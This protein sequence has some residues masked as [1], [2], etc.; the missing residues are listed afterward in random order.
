MCHLI[1]LTLIVL[2]INSAIYHY[3]RT[4]STAYCQK[5]LFVLEECLLQIHEDMRED[6]NSAASALI[7]SIARTQHCCLKL[8]T[9][10]FIYRAFTRPKNEW[11]PST[12]T[13]SLD[14]AVP[15][16]FVNFLIQFKGPVISI[17]HTIFLLVL[18]VSPFN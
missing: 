9:R 18:E 3:Y 10:W 15:A 14:T 17:F 11:N 6:T 13:N 8:H 12:N 16:M 2:Q 1:K 4:V 5:V 7:E